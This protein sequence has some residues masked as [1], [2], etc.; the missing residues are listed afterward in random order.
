MFIKLLVSLGFILLPCN[1]DDLVKYY[2]ELVEKE[3]GRAFNIQLPTN[4]S[5][6]K[7]V[8]DEIQDKELLQDN[9][10]R[11][12]SGFDCGSFDHVIIGAGSAGAV[13]A[14]RLSEDSNRQVLLLEAG[15]DK[16]DFSDIPAMSTLL[17]GLEYNWNYDTVPQVN[18]CL[19]LVEN[20]CKFHKGKGVGG[21]SLVN[22]LM[23]V[24]GN[25]QD[26]DDW[27]N[28]GNI[29]WS[30][31]DVLPYFKKSE[32]FTEGDPKYHGTD[33][34]WNVEKFEPISPQAKAFFEGTKQLGYKLIDYN[35]L[36]QIG[37]G[38]V[39]LNIRKGKRQSSYDAFITP[40]LNRNNLKVKKNAFVTKILINE[41]N[42]A[43]GVQFNADGKIC[44]VTSKQDIILSAGSIGSPQIL[45][46]SGIGPKSHLQDLGIPVVQDLDVG[47]N[48]MDHLVLSNTEFTSNY[49]EVNTDFEK[50]LEDY[51]KGKGVLTNSFNV[52][53]LMFHKTKIG[54][55]SNYP[56]IEVLLAPSPLNY[57]I[58]SR[59]YNYKEDTYEAV[60]KYGNIF[61][62]FQLLML[63]LHPKKL[64]V[65]LKYVP[66]PGCDQFEYL[67]KQYWF[68]RIKYFANS[69]YHPVGTCKMGPDASKGAVVDS[70]LKVYGITNLRVADSS[71]MP[72][73][74]SGHTN[75]PTIMI[76]ERVADFIKNI[77]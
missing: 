17:Q 49:T 14:S 1:D 40:F 45:M 67:S 5:E 60:T 64:D 35:G 69:G 22:A 48:L 38:K 44:K 68:C 66:I 46:L 7:P 31:K 36:E 73:I 25:K 8:S 2:M 24:R 59:F 76:G 57:K 20:R 42:K 65:K 47:K 13:A 55:I 74:T 11:F 54:N 18:A 77:K 43:Y 58:S 27:F 4:A 23:Y 63:G 70:K 33:G 61:K 37:Y 3:V 53:G 34:L 62:N 75:A 6:Y 29:G 51:L 16:S 41:Q 71:I 39:L 15:G 52:Q 21:T 12:Y 9:N 50:N 72:L 30:F 28:E 56:D 19:A 32:R 10:I 26:Y